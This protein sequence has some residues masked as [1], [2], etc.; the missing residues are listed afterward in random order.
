MGDKDSQDAFSDKRWGVAG[1]DPCR[2]LTSDGSG[3][4][5]LVDG[6]DSGGPLVAGGNLV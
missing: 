6:N 1:V 3:A 4:S 5:W 2:R